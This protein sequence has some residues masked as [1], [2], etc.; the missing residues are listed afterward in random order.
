M[1]LSGATRT[2]LFRAAAGGLRLLRYAPAGA[3][4]RRKEAGDECK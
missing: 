1:A 4:E 3:D 2:W